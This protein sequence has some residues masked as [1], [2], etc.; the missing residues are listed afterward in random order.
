MVRPCASD[1]NKNIALQFARMVSVE[2][3]AVIARTGRWALYS[4][5][6]QC[7]PSS[8]RSDDPFIGRHGLTEAEFNKVLERNGFVKIR[9]HSSGASTTILEG[10]QEQQDEDGK[11]CKAVLYFFS[12]RRWRNP[13]DTKDLE[14]LRAA[15]QQ[16]A[17]VSTVFV[18]QCKFERLCN[19]IRTFG[20][21]W[22]EVEALE[23]G[24]RKTQRSATSSE[25]AAPRAQKR[26][27]SDASLYDT[28]PSH[29]LSPNRSP[30]PDQCRAQSGDQ[31]LPGIAALLSATA[32]MPP[33]GVSMIQPNG[34]AAAVDTQL[35]L[36][37][38]SLASLA[39]PQPQPQPQPH[40][41]QQ[42]Q[43]VQ[44]SQQQLL[45]HMLLSQ[46]VQQRLPP[47]P[48]CAPSPPPPFSLLL[49]PPCAPSPP[50]PFLLPPPPPCAPSPGSPP[51]FSPP[52]APCDY[53]TVT[54][55]GYE[56]HK[57]SFA[58]RRGV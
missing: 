52:P 19:V 25:P 6:K 26:K 30:G 39:Q 49:P 23:K 13:D 31:G 28:T 41:K 11:G 50:P 36:A 33:Y 35:V 42:Q 57:R 14:Q 32:L 45:Q 2:G 37:L 7:C 10:R 16:L 17:D 8:I 22:E 15:W 43:Q 29:W 9:D 53:F 12:S 44:P 4:A 5:L 24:S 34:P 58:N 46:L 55:L 1:D 40:P 21:E 38:L 54:D 48:P 56:P 47:P 3:S 27:L 20:R 18:G 51:A